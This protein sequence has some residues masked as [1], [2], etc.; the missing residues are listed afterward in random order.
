MSALPSANTG[1]AMFSPPSVLK[2]R[3][4]RT[5]DGR[6]ALALATVDAEVGSHA[7]SRSSQGGDCSSSP[8]REPTRPTSRAMQQ[9]S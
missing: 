1:S 6:E 3:A 7:P 4:Y 5:D 2:A 8:G 9:G